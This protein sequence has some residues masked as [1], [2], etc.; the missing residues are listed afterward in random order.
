MIFGD[1]PHCGG[2]IAT[3]I[4]EDIDLP[5]M[6]K[7]VCEHCGKW[8]WEHFSRIDP[9]AY[10]PEQVEVDEENMTVKVKEAG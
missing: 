6:G 9:K 4:P 2:G 10:L 7:I 8:F 3:A 1:C 5:V